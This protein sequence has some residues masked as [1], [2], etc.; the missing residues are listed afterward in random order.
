MLTF[1]AIT[2][3]KRAM[4]PF[5]TLLFLFIAMLLSGQT[6]PINYMFRVYLTDKGTTDYSI[7]RPEEF[8]TKEAIERK[9]IQ[10][11]LIDS[12]DFPI[13][14]D[15]FMMVQNAGADVVSFSKWFDLMVVK[16]EDST[17]I[18]S[19]AKL[20]FVEKVEYVWRG[21]GNNHNKDIRPRLLKVPCEETLD[22]TSYF[23]S[24][25][26]QYGLHN[27]ENLVLSGFRGKGMNIAIIDAGFTNADVIPLFDNIRLNGISDFVSNGTIFNSSDHGTRVLSTMVTNLPNEMIGSASEADYLLLRSEDTRSEFPVEEDYW[28]R[29]VEFADSMGIDLINTS[30]G[31][32]NFDDP[33]LNH[34]YSNLDGKTTLMTQAADKAFEKGMI[35]VVS[36]GNEGNKPWKYMTPPADARNVLS[37]GAIGVDST[38]ASFSSLGPTFDLRIKP[39]LLSV[40]KNTVTIGQDGLIGSTN[41]TSLSAPFMAGLIA[42][43]W[44]IHPELNRCELINI[45]KQSTDRYSNPD[46]D[47]GYGYGIPDFGKSMK[48][49]LQTLV[50][51]QKS[52]SDN[53]I[54]IYPEGDQYII[55]LIDP[56]LFIRGYSVN[57]LGENGELIDKLMFDN[58]KMAHFPKS[59][60]KEMRE[61]YF[62]VNSPRNQQT[63]RIK[64]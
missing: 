10:N 51:N 35:L 56:P 58:Q 46:K 57:L 39:D 43:L 33:Q 54:T 38:I 50:S 45:I 5:I 32:N 44:S 11:V 1:V 52:F 59:K 41:G 14:E 64:L 8:L 12:T 48:A 26:R 19:I 29:A 55:K 25:K 49:V 2:I 9:T 21:E 37:I 28:I 42:S 16:V 30:L 36:M 6:I 13:D 40:G 22:S 20:P 18:E 61:V 24:T 62:V 4:K 3:F 31:Y 27:A 7:S 17:R 63:I 60:L 53:N 23:G 34:A 15:Y 47:T